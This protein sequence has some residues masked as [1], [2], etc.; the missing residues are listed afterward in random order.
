MKSAAIILN[1]DFNREIIGDEVIC[2]DGGYNYAKA[3]GIKVDYVVGD[4][5]S[6]RDID[7]DVKIVKFNKVKDSTDGELAIRYAISAGYKYLNMYGADGG[8]LDHVIYN[9]HLMAIA[10]KLGAKCVIRADRYDVYY[11]NS[12]F[13]L[14]VNP[15]DI[16]SIVPFSSD[17][18]I[19]ST[20]GLEYDITDED[21]SKFTTIGVSNIAVSDK[22]KV[23]VT[24]GDV[25]IFRVFRKEV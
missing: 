4:L 7:P 21:M 18:H 3:K 6:A 5:D 1:S 14:N 17:V 2:A 12:T 20:E 25:N 11:V 16:I 8:R 23:V 15:G 10:A 9:V 22:I 24:R 13:E 19:M